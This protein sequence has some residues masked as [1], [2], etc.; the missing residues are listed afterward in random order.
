MGLA[1]VVRVVLYTMRAEALS[2]LPNLTLLPLAFVVASAFV[3]LAYTDKIPT[4]VAAGTA[5]TLGVQTEGEAAPFRCGP[6]LSVLDPPID[7]GKVYINRSCSTAV[8]LTSQ[9]PGSLEAA[10]DAE[11]VYTFLV[12]KLPMYGGRV[13]YYRCTSASAPTE[14]CKVIIVVSRGGGVHPER[15]SLPGDGLPTC[16]LSGTTVS[17][18]LS[19]RTKQARFRCGPDVP[20]LDPP[21]RDQSVYL[22]R[23]C[24]TAVPLVTQG[25]A[26]LSLADEGQNLFVLTAD[27]LPAK[28][29]KTLY[30]RCTDP[31]RLEAC[32]VMLR[33]PRSLPPP[34]ST[35]PQPEDL[36][37]CDKSGTTLTLEMMPRTK[38]VQ[39]GCGGGMF[40]LDP[41]LLS[42]AVYTARSCSN[43]V[44]L[45]TQVEGYIAMSPSGDNAYRLYVKDL[46]KFSPKVFFYQC[47]S[48]GKGHV[49]KISIRVP[50]QSLALG[51]TEPSLKPPT[52]TENGATTAVLLST[53]TRTAQFGCSP[54]L[55]QLDPPLGSLMA[56]P[57]PSCTT[58]VP[59][60]DL[61]T[62]V[63][64]GTSGGHNVYTLSVEGLPS[65]EPK[66][67]YFLCR[68]PHGGEV[69]KVLIKVPR[70]PLSARSAAPSKVHVCHAGHDA[71]IRI[72]ASAYGAYYI[73][74]A[75]G[76]THS[77]QDETRVYDDSDGTCSSLVFLNGVLRGAQLARAAPLGRG[78]GTT[79]VFSTEELPAEEKHL[80]FRCAPNSN[81]RTAD[82][83]VLITVP[84]R[85]NAEERTATTSS[86]PPSTIRSR[87]QSAEGF[88]LVSVAATFLAS[89]L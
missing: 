72:A 84:G 11:G 19:A 12:T 10:P 55:R 77:P 56:Y 48:P 3:P 33:I 36:A 63:V 38:M 64:S 51:Q 44:Q 15:A 80:C 24:A 34:E 74:C 42:G 50:A 76:L 60:G 41:P 18:Q 28:G 1:A 87:S 8:P 23:S 49:C 5:V 40:L 27:S 70:S 66:D 32:K 6:E 25:L 54:E 16:S 78:L 67:I 2:M 53:E 68:A 13:L 73:R 57:S 88:L 85:R 62:G 61:V 86:V 43:A 21:L 79:Y 9:V 35:S 58:A 59:L 37:I 30:Y 69:C 39:F 17:V 22:S 82:C 65:R 29:P 14:A 75:A 20:F 31:S 89:G 71:S 26:S 81:L 7:S 45:K 83:R 52:C 4:C 47:Q 46:P